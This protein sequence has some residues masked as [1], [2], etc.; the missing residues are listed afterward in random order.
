ML[1]GRTTCFAVHQ[2]KKGGGMKV[3]LLLCLILVSFGTVAHAEK[4]IICYINSDGNI[5]YTNRECP[6]GYFLVNGMLPLSAKSSNSQEAYT[7]IVPVE[8]TVEVL[9][10]VKEVAPIEREKESIIYYDEDG[11][12]T[13]VFND[14]LAHGREWG[15]FNRRY[16]GLY[17]CSSVSRRTYS[18]GCSDFSYRRRLNFY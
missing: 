10:A 7:P 3:L 5:I 12:L 8:S 11:N 15:Y 13:M 2:K 1:I 16:Y 14:G 9:P 18:C 17:R 4:D 6:D